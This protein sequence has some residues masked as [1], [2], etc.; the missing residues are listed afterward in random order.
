MCVSVH[1]SVYLSEQVCASMC[2]F[3][4]V[5]VCA[6]ARRF[7][8]IRTQA[9]VAPIQLATRR[10]CVRTAPIPSCVVPLHPSFAE[11]RVYIFLVCVVRRTAQSNPLC[12]DS[13]TYALIPTVTLVWVIRF[14][15]RD[16]R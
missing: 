2:V 12:S 5:R 10:D 1:A 3:V 16:A 15:Y 8:R 4:R 7:S 14:R 6:L 13:E 9:H 11:T